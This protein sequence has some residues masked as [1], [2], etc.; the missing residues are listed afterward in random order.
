MEIKDYYHI[1]GISSVAT[2][3][4]IKAAYRAKAKKYHP[5]SNNGNV[6]S[7]EMFKEIAEAYAVLH[8]SEERKKYHS[9][10]LR[11]FNYNKSA[12]TL[13]SVLQRI[14][15]L[16]H[17]AIHADPFR[18]DKDLLFITLKDICP[19]EAIAI[20]KEE[21]GEDERKKISAQMIAL[22]KLL[23]YPDAEKIVKTLSSFAGEK[24][25]VQAKKVLTLHKKEY[26]W[27]KYKTWIAL[28]ISILLGLIIFIT[29]KKLS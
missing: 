23:R 8:R 25:M 12:I 9:L 1:L 11:H 7:A 4:E 22:L 10:W 27:N 6:V 21:T 2:Q 19:D 5:D 24:Q 13:Q 18:I 14:D 16:H 17:D 28:L 29:G 15:I 20:I 26:L 3:A